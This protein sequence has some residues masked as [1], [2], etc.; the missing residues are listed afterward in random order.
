[1][2]QYSRPYTN[3]LPIKNTNLREDDKS[4]VLNTINSFPDGATYKT[5]S[6]VT[7]IALKTL[8]KLLN[9]LEVENAVVATREWRQNSE[10]IGNCIVFRTVPT[11][12]VLKFLMANDGEEFSVDSITLKTGEPKQAAIIAIETLVEKG[13]VDYRRHLDEKLQ[14]RTKTYFWTGVTL[15][16]ARVS[17]NDL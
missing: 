11:R 14:M 3:L 1:M 13:L 17:P 10:K 6:S 8:R 4:L 15:E 12:R 9:R 2:E 16:E 5:L 7:R